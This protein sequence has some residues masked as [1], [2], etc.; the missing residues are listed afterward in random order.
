MQDRW[1]TFGATMILGPIWVIWHL[2]LFI[3]GV[4]PP[5]TLIG[6][7]GLCLALMGIEI[8]HTWIYINTDKSVFTVILFHTV[9]N[10]VRF[11]FRTM[12]QE[13]GPLLQ[14]VPY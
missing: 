10:I 5:G 11:F 1:K 3:S 14:A 9:Y 8:F 4:I 2:P 6:I 13:V 7:I 12:C